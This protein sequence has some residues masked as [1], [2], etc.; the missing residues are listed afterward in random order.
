MSL[1]WHPKKK[2]KIPSFHLWFITEYYSPLKAEGKSLGTIV[3]AGLISIKCIYFTDY[4]SV[5]LFYI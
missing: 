4:F 5:I 1:I 2:P 3:T